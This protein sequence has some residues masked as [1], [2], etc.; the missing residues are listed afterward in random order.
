MRVPLLA[1]AE[2]LAA[3]K[4]QRAKQAMTAGNI[5]TIAGD[6]PLG[7]YSGDGGPATSATSIGTSAW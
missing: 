6:D 4:S 5:Y 2:N 7:G 1:Q 3:A